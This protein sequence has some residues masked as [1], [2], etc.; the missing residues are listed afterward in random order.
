MRFEL[1]KMD[2]PA[3]IASAVD[4]S[5]SIY[6]LLSAEYYFGRSLLI[7]ESSGIEPKVVF[8]MN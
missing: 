2:V 3:L 4:S 5:V 1:A 7:E 8:E 6:A